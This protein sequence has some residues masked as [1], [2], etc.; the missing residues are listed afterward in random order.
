MDD[1]GPKFSPDTRE[2]A[3]VMQ[4]S[5]YERAP[6]AS[7]V[8]RAGTGMY[9]HAGGLV[10]DRHLVVFE[11]DIE[12]DLLRRRAQG[13]DVGRTENTD[14]LATTQTKRC[15]GLVVID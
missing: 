6:I 13:F 9:H 7:I 15:L 10:D 5:I 12:G 2:F 8:G 3:E 4:Q 14:F 11:N 1:S